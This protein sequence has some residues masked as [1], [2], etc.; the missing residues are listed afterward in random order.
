MVRRSRSHSAFP[1]IAALLL[2]LLSAPV[3]SFGQDS[4]GPLFADTTPLALRITGPFRQLSRDSN[5]RPERD[6][7]LEYQGADGVNQAIAIE[8]RVRGRSRLNGCDFPP[9]SLD[10]A[11][12]SVTAEP[13]VG[14]NRLKL[15]TRC[16]SGSSYIDYLAKEFL[17][18]RM[19]SELTER[20]FRVRWASVEYVYS[21]TNR[22]QMVTAP[23]FLIEGDWEVADRL[24][25]E[26]IER[27]ELEHALL[28]APHASLFAMFQYVIGNTDWDLMHGPPGEFCCHNGK[29]V[30][31]ADG[32]YIVVP[33]DFD[34]SG[35][36]NA[37]YAVPNSVLPIRSVTQ[38]LYRGYCVM[39][40]EVEGAIAALNDRRDRMLA[41]FDD[42]LLDDDLL[43]EG[44]RE[45]A[46]AY[47][48]ESFDLINDP[49]HVEEQ[50]LGRC[51][52]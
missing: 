46:I 23:A 13:F 21:D 25:L 44:A 40:G 12:D 22:E 26:V 2:F 15:V 14:Q 24:A 33:Y 48:T 7:T 19:W 3:I 39:N 31:N 18:Y 51:R 4:S 5:E 43:S 34:N 29:V 1:S 47:V 37:E 41:I 27:D 49:E 32:P 36:I 30:G 45:R 16:K 52:E 42:G 6:A 8:I 10:F 11:R 35:L 20:S 17:V 28:D 50:I 38:R 9:L